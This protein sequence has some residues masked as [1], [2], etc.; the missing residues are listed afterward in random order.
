LQEGSKF[1]YEGEIQMSPLVGV[2]GETGDVLAIKAPG[3]NA[4]PRRKLASFVDECVAAIHKKA[5]ANYQLWLR[6]DSAGFSRSAVEAATRHSAA[7]SF[8][9]VQNKSIRR[10]IEALATNPETVWIPAKEADGEL[11]GSEVAEATYRFAKRDLR[12]FMRR[13][14]KAADEQLSFDDLGGERRIYREKTEPLAE[15]VREA[16]TPP[17]TLLPWPSSYAGP[18]HRRQSLSAPP[19][20]ADR[21]QSGKRVARPTRHHRAGTGQ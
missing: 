12:L 3:G 7:F 17:P 1:S 11:S 18:V 4:S 20:E 6:V 10:A 21:V 8:T 19:P 15:E 9:C 14:R 2:V 13:Q 16:A 5:R